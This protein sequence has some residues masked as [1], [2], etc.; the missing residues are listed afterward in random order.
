M[1]CKYI[2][3][4]LDLVW[5][6]K[7][8]QLDGYKFKTKNGDLVDIDGVNYA[9]IGTA[10]IVEVGDK[11][12]MFATEDYVARNGIIAKHISYKDDIVG[13]VVKHNRY[14]SYYVV[15]DFFDDFGFVKVIEVDY[16]NVSKTNLKHIS[17]TNYRAT[18]LSVKIGDV[19]ERSDGRLAFVMENQDGVSIDTQYISY[20]NYE[21]ISRECDSASFVVPSYMSYSVMEKT[22]LNAS[23]GDFIKVNGSKG[24]F[25]IND[26][27]D[28]FV[29]VETNYTP[30]QC[31]T[32]R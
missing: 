18:D 20:S 13:M 28:N 30:M 10:Y 2:D 19:I 14:N 16:C 25:V 29:I 12:I 9:D 3:T 23:V 32:N 4:N 5:Q 24:V 21:N 27:Y 22:E 1:V 15:V 17:P 8:Y 7:R 26:V 11:E 6:L 31:Q